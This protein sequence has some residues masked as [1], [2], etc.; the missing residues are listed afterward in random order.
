MTVGLAQCLWS[1]PALP[2]VAGISV[3]NVFGLSLPLGPAG[4][5]FV[6]VHYVS[7]F[8]DFFDTAFILLRRK[9]EQFSFL[10]V[11]HHASIGPVWGLLLLLGFGSGTPVFGAFIN[12]LVHVL[13]YSHYLVASFGVRNPLKRVLTLFQICQFYACIAHAVVVFVA[14][15]EREYIRG[16]AL[17]Q[18]V[19]HVSMIVLFSS[20]YTNR[21]AAGKSAVRR[22][23]APQDKAVKAQ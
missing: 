22:A 17:L 10:H 8:L 15:F 16:L 1:A 5:W 4:E 11:Y 20:F 18:I 13:M 21:Y 2:A 6:L 9:K 23:P 14:P 3:P 19:Y 12:S 7:K